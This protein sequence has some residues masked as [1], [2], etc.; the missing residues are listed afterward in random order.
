MARKNLIGVSLESSPETI[1]DSG[2]ASS[3][4]LS[5]LIPVTRT[6]PIGGI[7]K[8]LGNITQKVERA[9]E[10]ERQL[11]EGHSVVE[12]DPA[13]IDC[14]FIA[15]RI[16]IDETALQELVEQ[17]RINGQLVPILVRPHPKSTVRYQVA[18][19]H[20]R[21]AA[22]K[23]L[24]QK[25]KAVI[26]VLT[27]EQLVVSQ[28]QEN[29]ARSN[30][31]YIERALFG[32]KLETAGFSRDIVMSALNVDKAALSKMLS[33]VKHVSPA[34]IEVIGPA[35]VIGRRR[36]MDLA[37]RINSNDQTA[38]SKLLSAD[39]FSQMS[40]DQRFQRVFEFA[41]SPK[42]LVD[43][44]NVA[45]HS[46]IA[47]DKSLSLTLSKKS[48]TIAIELANAEAEPFSNW[49]TENLDA[50]YQQYLNKKND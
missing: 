40:S 37:E 9:G 22:L 34:L 6:A 23:I 48:K 38:F 45:A 27:D 49:L 18:F 13:D 21:L 31:S 41:S 11:A 1:A 16:A 7:S 42:Q 8:S 3:R 4:P 36:W 25:V 29:N 24:G 46:W 33:I 50:L 19:G 32:A 47:K 20:R 30:L 12:L 14:S 39:N 5:G 10:L 43:K 44:P 26:R 15:D 28:G 2:I 35:P 17:I